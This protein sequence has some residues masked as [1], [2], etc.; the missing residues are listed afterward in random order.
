MPDRAIDL[1][2]QPVTSRKKGS[3]WLPFAPVHI[4]YQLPVAE[5]L[6]EVDAEDEGPQLARK[7]IVTSCG[8][9]GN[10]I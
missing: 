1:R 5:I 9:M 10:P 2:E 4:P 6:N 3:H 8:I 7:I